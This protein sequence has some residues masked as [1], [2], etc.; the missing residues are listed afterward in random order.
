MWSDQCDYNKNAI[1][2]RRAINTGQKKWWTYF[3]LLSM[4]QFP[5]LE[6]WRCEL[7][8]SLM[9]QT[10]ELSKERTLRKKMSSFEPRKAITRCSSKISRPKNLDPLTGSLSRLVANQYW[11]HKCSA[12]SKTAK[13]TQTSIQANRSF[14]L[15]IRLSQIKLGVYRLLAGTTAQGIKTQCLYRKELLWTCLTSSQSTSTRT[16]TH[17]SKANLEVKKTSMCS[18]WVK[19]HYILIWHDTQH[20]GLLI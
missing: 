7:Y 9:R 17:C 16:G 13:Q 4:Y 12:Q 10:R 2:W 14:N 5:Q 6:P 3:S 15:L 11:L 20:W 8:N 1:T 19:K 18:W